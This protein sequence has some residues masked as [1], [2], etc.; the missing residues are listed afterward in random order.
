M[1]PGAFTVGLWDL[2]RA[3]AR[4]RRGRGQPWWV[5]VATCAERTAE[6]SLQAPRKHKVKTTGY[7]AKVDV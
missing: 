6:S 5:P 2:L 4:R 7:M 1:E 3:W